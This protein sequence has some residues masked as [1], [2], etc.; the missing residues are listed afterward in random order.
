M[1]IERHIRESTKAKTTDTDIKL[2]AAESSDIIN[3][4][5]TRPQIRHQFTQKELLLEALETE[6]INKT[7]LESQKFNNSL[8]NND[9][10]L[11]S[12]KLL[13]SQSMIRKLSRRGAYNTITFTDEALIPEILVNNNTPPSIPDKVLMCI[14]Y[15]PVISL[16]IYLTIICLVYVHCMYTQVCVITGLPARYRDPVTRMPYANLDAYKEIKA[17]YHMDVQYG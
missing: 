7:W 5:E 2:K 4:R 8:S 17:R 15:I 3:K 10:K 9:D 11:K 14:L 16:I 6:K 12:M 1:H 13:S